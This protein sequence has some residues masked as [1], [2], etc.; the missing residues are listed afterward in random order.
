MLILISPSSCGYINKCPLW[1]MHHGGADNADDAT[2]DDNNTA[3]DYD[4]QGQ[5]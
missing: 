2:E 3:T 4:E 5:G 1:A